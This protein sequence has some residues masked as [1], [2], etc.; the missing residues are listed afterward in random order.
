M[1]AQDNLP[2]NLCLLRSLFKLFL[3]RDYN[4]T[5]EERYR[6]RRYETVVIFVRGLGEQ[7]VRGFFKFLCCFRGFSVSVIHAAMIAERAA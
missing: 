4:F 7:G 6:N 5:D 1:I 2:A 3:E